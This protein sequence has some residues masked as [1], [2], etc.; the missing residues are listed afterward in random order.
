MP[1]NPSINQP[2]ARKLIQSRIQFSTKSYAQVTTSNTEPKL[3]HS[4]RSY[5][6]ILTKLISLTSENLPEFVNELKSS[7]N[8]TTKRQ[9]SSSTNLTTSTPTPCQVVPQVTPRVTPTL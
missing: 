4:C 6:A 9:P 7:L 3:D 2:E 5:H 1:L 8:E